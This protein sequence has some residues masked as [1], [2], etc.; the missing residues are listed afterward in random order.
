MTESEHGRRQATRSGSMRA[1][2]SGAIEYAADL[3]RVWRAELTPFIRAL[4]HEVYDPA[5]D[6]RKNLTDDEVR[7]FRAWK[8][9][10]LPR[11]QQALRKIIAWDL[12]WI[13]RSDYVVCY[14]DRAAGR[15]AGT[16]GELTYAHRIGRPVYLVLD[17]PAEQVSGWILG[18]A[19]Y[20]I[21]SFAALRDVLARQYGR[22]LPDVAGVT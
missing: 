9:A 2:L 1:Y 15:G 4:G 12:D 10:D 5:L 17:V 14:W 7:C 16:Q 21:P 20:V 13:D 19:T 22:A 18:C 3:G 11:F 6:E 8:A